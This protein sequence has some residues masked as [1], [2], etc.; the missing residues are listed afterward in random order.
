MFYT[1][2]KNTFGSFALGIDHRV[3][4]SILKSENDN[5][6][7]DDIILEDIQPDKKF[8]SLIMNPHLITADVRKDSTTDNSYLNP[9][10]RL[11][12]FDK[13]YYRVNSIKKNLY[14]WD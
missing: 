11:I 4:D 5:R 14:E 9:L 3:Y 12:S 10:K 7:A 8:N 13:M 6:P 1:K 2:P